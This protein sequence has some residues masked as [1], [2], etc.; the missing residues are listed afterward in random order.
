LWRGLYILHST[1]LKTTVLLIA[2]WCPTPVDALT[3]L[4]TNRKK[5]RPK[6]RLCKF[7]NGKETR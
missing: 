7:L 2:Q 4:K 3:K 6:S 5:K 1:D